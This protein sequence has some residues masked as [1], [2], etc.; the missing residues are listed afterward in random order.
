MSTEEVVFEAPAAPAKAAKKKPKAKAR[1]AAPKPKPAAAPF[2]GL[3]RTVCAETCNAKACAIS[4]K[5]YCAHPTKG[6]L[7]AV[8]LTNAAAMKRL[9]VARE[10]IRVKIDPDRFT[11]D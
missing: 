6:G 3:T 8:D 2:P 4:G 9:Q 5:P 10:Q 7:Q 11:G 1:G